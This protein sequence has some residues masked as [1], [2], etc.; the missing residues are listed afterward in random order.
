[1]YRILVIN[2]GSTSTKL[3]IFEDEKQVASKTLRHTPEEL[4]QFKRLIDQYEFRVN[5]IE[6]FLKTLGFEYKD[7]NAVVG[8]GGLVRP[9]PSG[10]YLVDEL[11]VEELKQAKYGEHASNL[12]AVIAFEISNKYNIPAYIVDPVVVDEMD[13]IAKIS[14]HPMFERKSIFHALNQKAVARRA[15]EELGKK[16][17]E[18]NL[19]VVHMGGGISIGAHRN[20]KVIDVNNALDGDGPF[21]PERSGTLPLT[22][23]IDLCYSGKYD[24]DFI[25]KRI[26]G[27]GGLVAYL[28]T[29]DAMKVQ[30]MISNGDKKAELVYKAM[31]YQIAKWIGKMAAALKGEVDAI[32]LTGGLAYDE[33]YMV[34][35]LKEYTGFIAK[36][37]VY[38]GGDE[39]KALAMGALRVLRGEEKARSYKE[40]VQMRG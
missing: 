24:Y 32:V 34:K 19:I 25:K 2:P 21:T 17:E 15:A 9:I 35:W 18:T 33:N 4:S 5:A 27:K 23:L 26:K 1:M 16:Y 31:A 8:R 37:L 3:A 22:Q 29:N 11:M 13:K 39:E 7:F 6:D 30:E 14:G 28:G 40:E 38:P 10:T 20:G 36:V 12:G